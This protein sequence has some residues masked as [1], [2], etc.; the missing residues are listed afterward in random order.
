LKVEFQEKADAMV[1]DQN[2]YIRFYNKLFKVPKQEVIILPE[3]PSWEDEIIEIPAPMPGQSQCADETEIDPDNAKEKLLKAQLD[4]IEKVFSRREEALLTKQQQ[5][6]SELEQFKER[7]EMHLMKE[8]QSQLQK[9]SDSAMEDKVG[10]VKE[11]F[12]RMMCA[13]SAHVGKERERLKALHMAVRELE[14][15]IKE[16]WVGNSKLG[17]LEDGFDDVPLSDCGEFIVQEFNWDHSAT[18]LIHGDT[19]GE[20]AGDEHIALGLLNQTPSPPPQETEVVAGEVMPVA[21]VPQGETAAEATSQH[22]DD[23]ISSV[24]SQRN[25]TMGEVIFRTCIELIIIAN[26]F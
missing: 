16:R 9:L 6:V 19:S 8:H 22:R 2:P 1:A 14:R 7:E 24:G 18:P 5:E 20:R 15:S 17:N 3:S 26:Y 11:E 21:A 23:E 13:F 25:R 12:K 10:K 4:L